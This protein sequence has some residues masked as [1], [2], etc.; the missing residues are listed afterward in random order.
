MTEENKT[1][2][3]VCS[4]HMSNT[5]F[6]SRRMMLDVII[7]LLPIIGMS[8]WVFHEYAERQLLTCIVTALAT[9]AIFTAVRKR[10]FSLCDG[11]A[12]VTALILALSLPGTAPWY[13]GVIAS[14][15]A[16]SLG[17]IVFGGLGQNLFNP[18]MVGRAFVMIAFASAMGA[19][20]YVVQDANIDVMTSATPLTILKTSGAAEIPSLTNLFI[21]NVNGSL[22]ETS[23]LACLL[24]GIYLCIR[25]TAAF[26]IP[27]SAIVTVTVIAL[28]GGAET[29]IP[30]LIGGAFLFGAFFIATDP[31]SSPVTPKGRWIFG[32]LFGALVMMLRKLSGY[33]EG[34]MFAV[35][36]ANALAPLINR[37]TIPTPLGGP[38]PVRN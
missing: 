36:L 4:P 11:S 19:G 17:K 18:A 9:E 31:V 14:V 34:V 30:H 35:L 10:P 16:V 37:W 5:S 32:A 28:F 21:G 25:R 24:G 26:E 20:A 29:V 13:V 6:T 15:I 12:L 38:V 22:G 1:L 3:I 2:N 33:P 27:L 23:A 8:L 7:A